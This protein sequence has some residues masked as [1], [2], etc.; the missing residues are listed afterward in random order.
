M[1]NNPAKFS[2]CGPNCPIENI[3]WWDAIEYLNRLSS[4][5]GL[6]RCYTLTDC[7]GMPG[8]D[9]E[10]KE[11]DFEG[12]TCTG[13]RLPTEAEWE[14]AAR[15]GTTTALGNGALSSER[16]KCKPIDEKLSQL[17]WYCGNA[18]SKT[19]TVGSLTPN[20]LGIHDMLG[21][22]SEWV[23]DWNQ[24]DHDAGEVTDPTGPT[25]GAGRTYRGGSW[26]SHAKDSR[27]ATRNYSAPSFKQNTLGFRP[28]R[29]VR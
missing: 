14:Y 28:V 26:I 16:T 15:A 12:V 11:V 7:S 21:N 20:R 18:Q 23:W 6:E 22:V 3:S 10:C 9:L 5:E 2:E 27:L 19:H 8:F 24:G 4:A 13:F 1:G 29:S 17:S 25:K